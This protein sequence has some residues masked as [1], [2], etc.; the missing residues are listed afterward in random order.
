MHLECL[1][2]NFRFVY[3]IL[4][5]S[6]LARICVHHVLAWC[7]WRPEEGVRPSGTGVTDAYECTGN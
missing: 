2:K 7:P 5:L 6:V 3:F 1:I 4:C